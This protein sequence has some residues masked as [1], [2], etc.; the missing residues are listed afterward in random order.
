MHPI[1]APA[2]PRTPG[3]VPPPIVAETEGDDAYPQ[4]RSEFDHRNAAALIVVVQVI[5]V[6]PAAITF[7]VDIAPGPVIDAAVEIQQRVGRNGE[8]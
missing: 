3:V 1:I 8:H 5:A 4:L 6:D 7:P 2:I